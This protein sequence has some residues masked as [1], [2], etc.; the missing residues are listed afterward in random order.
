MQQKQARQGVLISLACQA[1][2]GTEILRAPTGTGTGRSEAAALRGTACIS[3]PLP[4]AERHHSS[5]N[6]CTMLLAWAGQSQSAQCQV[7][8]C[9]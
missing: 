8:G 1:P 2:A 3:L 7:M 9:S 5:C 4:A 6:A